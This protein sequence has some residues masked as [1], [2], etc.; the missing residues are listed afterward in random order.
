VKWL[1]AAEQ[2]LG[3]YGT[4]VHYD[5]LARQIVRR[6][7]V[8]TRSNTPAIT[9]HASV[10]LDLRSRREKGLPPRFT[11]G[12]GMVGLAGWEP[13]PS[14][15]ARRIIDRTRDRAKRELLSGLRALS[16]QEF[17]SF[18]EVL[19]SEMG[20]SVT[21]I[22]GTRA[23]QGIDLVAEL[24]GG[25]ATQRIGIQAKCL[26][27]SREVGPS[28]IRLL[29]DALDTQQCNAGAVVATA[30]FNA[31]ARA[32]SAEP[33]KPPVELIDSARLVELAVEYGVGVR[34]QTIAE[35]HA[36]LASVFQVTDDER[37]GP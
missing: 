11:I 30:R 31:E 23:D 35:Y 34:S 20:Y 28:V 25:A 8:Q 12:Q 18:L 29:R 7:L 33:G 3:D 27:P 14:D 10:S 9:L 37:L 13:G 5:E 19:L 21:V 2:V 16:G 4:P 17:E 26:G 24:A 1:D 22:G 36:D 6:G 32:V 15:E